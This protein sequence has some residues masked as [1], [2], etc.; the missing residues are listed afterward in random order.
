MFTFFKLCSRRGNRTLTSITAHKIFLLLLFS[1]PLRFVVWTLPSSC[2]FWF[3]CFPSSLYTF[4]FRGLARYYHFK[5]FTDFEKFYSL[6]LPKGTQIKNQVLRV[7]QFHH[8]TIFQRTFCDPY[9]SWTRNCIWFKHIA[10]SS[11]AKGP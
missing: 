6:D 4:L 3:R 11:C 8:P 7:Y 1:Q 2:H 10:S 5:G 9:G